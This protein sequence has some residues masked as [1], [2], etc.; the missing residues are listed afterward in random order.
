MEMD[1]LS[2]VSQ[3][4]FPIAVAVYALVKLNATIATN[5]KVLTVIATKLGLNDAEV[6]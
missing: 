6:K 2:A 3:V 4:G 1:I 5:T